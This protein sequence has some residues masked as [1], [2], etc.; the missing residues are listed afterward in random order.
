MRG[1][2]LTSP[3]PTEPQPAAPPRRRGLSSVAVAVIG[4]MVLGAVGVIYYRHAHATFKVTGTMTIGGIQG[5]DIL[6]GLAGSCEGTGG[7]DD[8]AP[9][10][11]VVLTDA[12]NR[13]LAIG[14]VGY[15]TGSV[16]GDKTC[17]LPFEVDKVPAGKKFYGLQIGHR[18][19]V[20]YTEAEIK[21]GPALTIGG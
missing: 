1:M 2:A 9:G 20:Q 14:S 5:T 10:A 18:S 8:L 12:S 11:Q 6:T 19:A 21:D 4:I 13:T 17:T 15:G 16:L 3:E 7:Y